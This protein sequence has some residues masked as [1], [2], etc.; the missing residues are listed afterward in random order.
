MNPRVNACVVKTKGVYDDV[1]QNRGNQPS[2]E[3]ESVSIHHHQMA[4]P[5]KTTQHWVI[6]PQDITQGKDTPLPHFTI[7]EIH[8]AIVIYIGNYPFFQIAT[9]N[10][11]H[12]FQVFDWT[13]H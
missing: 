10:L 11:F 7:P 8:I 1:V 4:L 9:A 2:I 13:W 3:M 6:S 12:L 5:N